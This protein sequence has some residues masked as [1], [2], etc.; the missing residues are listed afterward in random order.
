MLGLFRY[1]EKEVLRNMRAIKVYRIPGKESRFEVFLSQQ[2]AKL[3]QKI[4]WSLYRLQY[5]ELC[6]LKEPH[7]KHFSLER[8]SPFYELREKCKILVRVIFT[9]RNEDIV[10]LTPFVKKESRDTMWAL[11]QSIGMLADIRTNPDR[12]GNFEFRKECN[13]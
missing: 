10:L 13:E 9:V 6:D 5:L 2:D 4:S 8:Y 1:T 7:Y 3:R 12:A 11:E